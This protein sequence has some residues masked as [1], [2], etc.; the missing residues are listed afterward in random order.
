MVYKDSYISECIYVHIV[1]S[2]NTNTHEFRK[3]D[4]PWN[5]KISLTQI[6]SSE[7]TILLEYYIY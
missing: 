1:C 7:Y 5:T 6:K 4:H 3:N 2:K